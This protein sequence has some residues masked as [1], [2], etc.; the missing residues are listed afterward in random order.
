MPLVQNSQLPTFERLRSSGVEV[1]GLDRAASQDIRELHI[2]LLNLMPDAALEATERQFFRLLGS[3]N[4]IAQ[5]HVHPFTVTGVER[6]PKAQ[7]HIDAFYQH[8]HEVREEGLDALVI[9]G[10]NPANPD[11]TQEGFWQQLLDVID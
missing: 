7:D 3:S 6:G 8:F 11:I 1:L 4:R 5:F 9:S 2:G 10:A